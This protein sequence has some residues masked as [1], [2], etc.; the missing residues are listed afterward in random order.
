[1]LTPMVE[2]DLEINNDTKI[3]ACA[4]DYDKNVHPDETYF[5]TNDLSLSNIANLFFGEDCI[6]K[7]EDLD[8]DTYRGY[9]RRGHLLSLQECRR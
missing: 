4:F 9:H 1:M 7:A 5:V 2:A 3:L 6:L 8:R